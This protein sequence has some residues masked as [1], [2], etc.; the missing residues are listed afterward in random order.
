MAHDLKLAFA[1]SLV[2][3]SDTFDILFGFL[4]SWQSVIQVAVEGSEVVAIELKIIILAIYERV[5]ALN[6]VVV[7]HKEHLLIFVVVADDADFLLVGCVILVIWILL[8]FLVGDQSRLLRMSRL[9]R[10]DPICMALLS[11]FF[12]LDHA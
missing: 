3:W 11:N 9:L 4:I 2:Y 10:V 12:R 7:L 8:N 6:L 5:R 1:I